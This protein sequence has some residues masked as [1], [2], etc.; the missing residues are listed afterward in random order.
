MAMNGTFAA[1]PAI[2]FGGEGSRWLLLR[3]LLVAFTALNLSGR[4]S[5]HAPMPTLPIDTTSASPPLT[6]VEIEKAAE[7]SAHLVAETPARKIA[8]ARHIS[9]LTWDELARVMSASRRSLHL[10]ANGG[11]INAVN[12]ERL[13]RLLGAL[14][15]IDRG[16]GSANRVAIFGEDKTGRIHFD[17]LVD[18]RFDEFTEI[19]GRGDG[20]RRVSRPAPLPPR[21][22]R[23]PPP[24]AV[25]LNALEDQVQ[26]KPM[27]IVHGKLGRRTRNRLT[28]V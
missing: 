23:E 2:D 25:L 1:A 13:A 21:A 14:R 22:N 16:T 9:G 6:L 26:A 12:E 19:L 10:W 7:S 28:P 24:P 5:A 8:E 20:K 15:A 18:G 4:T 11:A 27:R 3:N 17:L